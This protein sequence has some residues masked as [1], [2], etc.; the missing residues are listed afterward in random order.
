MKRGQIIEGTVLKT[1]YPGKGIVPFQDREFAVK[2]TLPGQEV[3]FQATKVRKNSSE[4]R[5]LEILKRSEQERDADCPHFDVCGGCSYRTLP[6]EAELR[7]KEQQISEL[8]QSACPDPHFE[9]IRPS[10][11]ET[12]YRNK[13]EFSFGDSCKG[14]ELTLGMHKRGSFYDVVTVD[15]C[16]IVDEDF[17]TILT[18]V[19]SRMQEEQLPYF[20][21]GSHE[22]Y[23]RHLLVRKARKT[24]QILVDLITT[25]QIDRSRE[26]EMLAR[27]VSD[28]TG[29]KTKGRIVGILHTQNDRIADVIEN[30][31]TQIL[32][33]QD[34]FCEELLGLKFRITPFSFFQT[35]SLGA[36]VLYEI[37]REY[38][39]DTKDKEVFDLYSGTGT[40]AQILAPVA[41]HVT[42]IEI[43]GEAVEAA[44]ENALLNGLENC[45]FIAGDVLK[46]ID[47]TDVKPD[48][49]V[50]DPPRDGIHPKALQKILDF[51]VPRIVYISCKATSLVRDLEMFFQRGYRIERSTAV[52][53]FPGTQHVES[54]V[55]LE[56]VSN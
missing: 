46:K 44:R 51:Q 2:N 40:I 47:E 49:L 4:G 9:G 15:G 21:R 55:L 56:R 8:L 3:R 37:A 33:G 23:L 7:M 50:L 13:M 28:L 12:E 41:G 22:G 5:L 48:L 54:C 11:L 38:I 10:P 34:W 19:L 20:H 17:R 36:E 1:V 25:S 35:N 24:E 53:M 52:D 43:V 32:W 31:H 26:Q 42:G 39:G 27:F 14:G 16:R 29:L 6:Y 30:E 45:T 18:A